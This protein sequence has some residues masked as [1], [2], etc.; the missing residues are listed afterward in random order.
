MKAFVFLDLPGEIRNLIYTFLLESPNTAEAGPQEDPFDLPSWRETGG[1]VS[2][3]RVLLEAHPMRMEI[4]P[5]ANFGY[6]RPERKAM[7]LCKQISR[8][9][10]ICSFLSVTLSS[11][12]VS[13][14][15]TFHHTGTTSQ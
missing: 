9:V 2:A 1:Y 4:E 14:T 5:A 13:T 12:C 8:E 15:K 3:D 7:H 11:L 10:T 6:G